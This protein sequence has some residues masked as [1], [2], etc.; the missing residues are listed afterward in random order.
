M[1]QSF[2]AGDAVDAGECGDGGLRAGCGDRCINHGE[3]D[4][5]LVGGA[6][7]AGCSYCSYSCS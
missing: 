5:A 3:Q 6:T 2:D 1:H 7:A 4:C